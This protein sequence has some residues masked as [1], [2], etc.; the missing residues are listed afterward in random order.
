MA[1]SMLIVITGR[2]PVSLRRPAGGESCIS[3]A[4][5]FVPVTASAR[6]L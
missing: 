3:V 4:P 1:V 5:T 6:G 2:V